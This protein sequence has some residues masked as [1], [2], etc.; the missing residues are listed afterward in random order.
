MWPEILNGGGVRN[1][2]DVFFIVSLSLFLSF[3]SLSRGRGLGGEPDAYPLYQHHKYKT[4]IY[5]HFATVVLPFRK[6]QF[7][8]FFTDHFY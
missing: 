6:N 5:K 2:E 8:Y 4:N 3:C 7:S 1:I